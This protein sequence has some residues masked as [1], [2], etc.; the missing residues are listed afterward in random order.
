MPL[1]YLVAAET[2]ISSISTI[3][4][5]FGFCFRSSCKIPKIK[6]ECIPVGCVPP[7]AVAVPGGAPPCTPPGTRH[8]HPPDQAPPREQAPPLPR[9]QV[10]PPVDRITDA[11]ENITLPQLRYGR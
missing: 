7:A 11:C 6:Q 8:P 9:E 5:C 1:K 3:T 4:M 10:P 2:T